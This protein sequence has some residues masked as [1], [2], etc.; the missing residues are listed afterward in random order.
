MARPSPTPCRNGLSAILRG[1]RA[2]VFQVRQS[3]LDAWVPWL[4]AEWE[5][6]NRTATEPW[7][8]AKGQGLRG[9]LRVVGEWATRRRRAERAKS[10]AR[11]RQE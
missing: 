1:E 2:D 6:G 3:W 9:S 11:P 8:R 4:D 5:A 10:D 7:R